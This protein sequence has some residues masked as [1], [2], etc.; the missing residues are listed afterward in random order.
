MN[1]II[2]RDGDIIKF[3][4]CQKDWEINVNLLRRKIR[5]FSEMTFLT[6]QDSEKAKVFVDF[7]KDIV[8]EKDEKFVA[9]MFEIFKFIRTRSVRFIPPVEQKDYNIGKPSYMKHCIRQ[10]LYKSEGRPFSFFC[11]TYHVRHTD[12]NGKSIDTKDQ[13]N[14][15]F[16]FDVFVDIDSKKIEDAKNKTLKIIDFIEKEYCPIEAVIFSGKKGYHIHIYYENLLDYFGVKKKDKYSPEEITQVYKQIEEKINKATNLKGFHSFRDKQIIKTPYTLHPETNLVA[17]PLTRE[18]LENFNLDL[19]TIE[20]VYKMEL[21]DR[22]T[23]IF[24]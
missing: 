3:Q 16:K 6:E 8:Q 21:R 17:L 14:E 1:P 22:G 20:N 7:Y 18:Q 9:W 15:P 11:S 10:Y 23:V 5:K 12:E 4:N 13:L 19:V 2:T 24:G